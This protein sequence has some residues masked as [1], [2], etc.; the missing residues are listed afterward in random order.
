M[1]HIVLSQFAQASVSNVPLAQ[2]FSEELFIHGPAFAGVRNASIVVTSPSCGPSGSTLGPD[3]TAE[4]S[5]LFPDLHWEPSSLDRLMEYLLVIEDPD[6]PLPQPLVHAV[7]YGIDRETHGMTNDELR[8]KRDAEY[9]NVVVGGFRYGKNYGN[10]VYVVPNPPPGT[11][12]RYFYEV[13]GLKERLDL[14]SLSPK[15]SRDEMASAIMGKVAGWGAW[16][17]VVEKK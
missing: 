15:P 14:D 17:G 9:D 16:M 12:H 10:N 8:P 11:P 7:Y 1:A 5:G 13:V 3:Y 2:G 6:A 4:G